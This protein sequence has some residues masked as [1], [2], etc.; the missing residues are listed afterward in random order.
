MWSCLYPTLSI[1]KLKADQVSTK[2]KG[3]E[4]IAADDF[5]FEVINIDDFSSLSPSGSGNPEIGFPAEDVSDND[6]QDD[7]FHDDDHQ[8]NGLNDDSEDNS[9]APE[10]ENGSRHCNRVADV[11]LNRL[12]LYMEQIEEYFSFCLR[13][14][15]TEFV[16][17]DF[18]ERSRGITLVCI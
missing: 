3:F 10:N 5:R 18:A 11:S 6:V 7:G 8:D 16:L 12:T 2:A 4:L 14:S 17:Q 13:L 15:E 1:K 9:N